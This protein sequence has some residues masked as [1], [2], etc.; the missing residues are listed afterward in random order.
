[1]VKEPAE[2][3]QAERREPSRSS[4]T[5]ALAPPVCGRSATGADASRWKTD[6][7]VAGRHMKLARWPLRRAICL[8][9][10]RNRSSRR[11]RQARLRAEGEFALARPEFDFERAQRHA[12]R[13][14]CRAGW[15]QA[16]SS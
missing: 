10:A 8:A 16:A 11:R 7:A 15:L 5:K 14:R 9:A 3:M 2:I 1:M 6:W 12:E 4:P 13:L